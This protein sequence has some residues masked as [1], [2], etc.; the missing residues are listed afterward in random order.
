MVLPLRLRLSLTGI[1]ACIGL[2]QGSANGQSNKGLLKK[3]LPATILTRK[4]LFLRGD[5]EPQKA[6]LALFPGKFYDLS[7]K[8]Y[9]NKLIS[10]ECKACKASGYPDVNEVEGPQ[11]FPYKGGV[12]TRLKSTFDFNDSAGCQYKVIS[13]SHSDY[14][15]DGNATG[16]F[17]GGL[18]GL[19]KFRRVDSGWQLMVFQPAIAA[20]GAFSEAPN[21]K[22]VKI[23]QDQYAFMI[24]H[25][26]G[27]AGGPFYGSF[28]LLAE[29]NGGYRQ[30]LEAGGVGRQDGED[31][32]KWEGSYKCTPVRGQLF[33]DIIVTTKGSFSAADP[34]GVPAELEKKVNN[35]DHGTFT[36]THVYTFRGIKGY[37]EKLPASISFTRK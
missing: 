20:Y 22:L 24:E 30:V 18:L 27:G 31:E 10:W 11:S 2:F 37:Q 13:F 7:D 3:N 6:L 5:F 29:V 25:V 32:G 26:N 1:L 14:D 19:A 28:Y 34:D 8:G 36:I 9:S 17:T 21:P 15:P 33:G 23:G 4:T 35:K 12:A 16:R